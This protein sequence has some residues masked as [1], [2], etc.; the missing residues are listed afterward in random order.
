MNRLL[1]ALLFS[2][3]TML[4]SA[5]QDLPAKAN[6]FI[7][8]LNEMQKAKALYPFDTA[9][10]YRFMYVPLDDR[11]GVSMNELTGAQQSAVLIC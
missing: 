4:Q 3:C 7:A 11:K 2:T 6:A 9:E 1:V 5:A 10:R 8:S